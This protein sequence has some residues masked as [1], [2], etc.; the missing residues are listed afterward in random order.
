L[1]PINA[2]DLVGL[3]QQAGGVLIGTIQ[4]RNCWRLI[5]EFDGIATKGVVLVHATAA[6]T[7][8]RRRA[9]ETRIESLGRGRGYKQRYA[10]QQAR[11]CPAT[12]GH[13]NF[14]ARPS[15]SPLRYVAAGWSRQE[16]GSA[17][18]IVRTEFPATSSGT[19]ED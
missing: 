5:P 1:Q 6:I 11:D 15:R 9:Q 2:G 13:R 17:L 18:S 14:P 4:L 16:V 12:T 10:D 7:R 3:I 8:L 19:N